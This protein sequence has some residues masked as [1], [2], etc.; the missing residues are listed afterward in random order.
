[1]R[2]L[3]SLCGAVAERQREMRSGEASPDG[4][5]QHEQGVKLDAGKPRP[6]LILSDMPRAML[7]MS[8]LA[9][10]GAEKYSPGSWQHVPDGIARYTDAMDRH[11]LREGIEDFE[12]DPHF[13]DVLHATQTAWNA[14][15]RLELILRERE[16]AQ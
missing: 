8:R 5:D 2:T 12:T 3:S 4:R 11:R 10:L 16:K 1:M 14:I 7:A 6:S 15:A 13:P 9:A